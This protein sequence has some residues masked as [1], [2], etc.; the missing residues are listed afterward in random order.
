M[1]EFAAVHRGQVVE[2]QLRLQPAGTCRV[3]A[4]CML[5]ADAGRGIQRLHGGR[6][7]GIRVFGTVA[8]QEKFVVADVAAPAAQLGG[9]VVAQG[10]PERVV[11]QLLQALVVEVGRGGQRGAD[12]QRQTGK[13]FEHGGQLKS[14]K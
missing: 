9:F 8:G 4:L 1:L 2:L 10:N 14:K 5:L 6:Q 7:F 12:K 3:N 13:A 11:G